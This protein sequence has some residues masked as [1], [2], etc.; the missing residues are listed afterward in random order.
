MSIRERDC[1]ECGKSFRYVT[2]R[3][4]DKKYCSDLCRGRASA[5][6][7]A[8]RRAAVTDRC[9]VDGCQGFATRI[10]A[11]MC[12]RH[13]CMQRRKGN[14]EHTEVKGR[15]RQ[16]AGYVLL[17]N[18]AH[19]LATKRGHV[20]EHRVVAYDVNCGLCPPC[21]WCG[22]SITWDECHVDH[23]NEKKDDNR[24]SNLVVTCPRCNTV[25]GKMLGMVLGMSGES[26]EIFVDRMRIQRNLA[27]RDTDAKDSQ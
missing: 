1:A 9:S 17:L 13:Y 27:D 18:K 6:T 3:G 26:F 20:Y 2:G 11:G 19:P 25:R 4:L 21:Y 10:K 16:D 14:T 5:H 7:A 15:Y 8:L 24:S 12:E 22:I 23:L